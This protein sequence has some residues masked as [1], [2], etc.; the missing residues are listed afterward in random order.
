ME[1][2]WELERLAALVKVT[3][4]LPVV[5]GLALRLRVPLLV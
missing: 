2:L 3:L 1:G 5:Q 4:G